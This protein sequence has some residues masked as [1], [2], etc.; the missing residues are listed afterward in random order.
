MLSESTTES[1]DLVTQAREVPRTGT[2]GAF[3]AADRTEV[4][5][6]WRARR[7]AMGQKALRRTAEHFSADDI[8]VLAERT[9][10]SAGTRVS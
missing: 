5:D 10:G 2:A 6:P 1:G 3:R 7:G 4:A 9:G 8:A